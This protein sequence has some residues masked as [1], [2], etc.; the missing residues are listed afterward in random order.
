MAKQFD[1]R[2]QLKLH[3]KGLLQRLLAEHGELLDFAWDSLKPLDV[4]PLIKEWDRIQEDKRR[5]VQVVLQD[6]NELADERS[7][8]ILL[9]ELQWRCPDKLATLREQNSPLDRA[10]WAYL[11]ARQAFDEAAIFARAEALRSGQFANRWNGLPS[12][13]IQMTDEL[14]EALQEEVR[15]YYWANELRGGVCRVHHYQRANGAE[16][17]FAYL[18][19]WP[20]RRLVFDADGNL[21]PREETY[22]FTN[23]FIY[24]PSEGALELIAKG[25]KKVHLSLRKAFCKAVLGIEVDDDEPV[26]PS[27]QL[28]HLLD[29]NFAF[30]TE[31]QD[32]I[33]AVRL[34]R[35]R[36]VPTISLPALEYLEPKFLENASHA[37]VMTTI[38]RLLGAHNLNRTQVTVAQ[39]GI[40]LQFLSDGRRRGKTMTFNVTYP[41]TCDLKSKPDD[42]RAIGERCIQRWGILQ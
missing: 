15:S 19:D 21:T 30:V 31:P 27:Y 20:D 29:P 4:E 37:D 9:E 8:R 40:Q 10:L 3:E 22:T 1:L 41:N 39:V 16:F 14:R 24:V 12:T 25:G 36:L 32:R 38:N 5:Q 26:R 17:F 42:V 34:R 28:D 18:P 11:E 13:R 33:A 7:H 23:V 6:V 2:K 35:I